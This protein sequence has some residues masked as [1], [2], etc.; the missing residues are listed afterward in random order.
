MSDR[1]EQVLKPF[2]D[3]K[4]YMDDRVKSGIE[5]YRKGFAALH[6]VD[7]SGK[8]VN[9]VHAE[10][11]QRTHDFRYGANLFM[12][13]ELETPEKNELYKQRFAEI[14]NLATL[15]F[16]WN[17]L[18]PEKGKQRYAADSPRIYR[19]PAPDLCIEYCKQHGI[20]PKMHCLCYDQTAP[21]WLPN[22][23]A[24]IRREYVRRMSEL[25]E[26]YEADIPS[27]EV[28][29]ETLFY[30][31]PTATAIYFD[32]DYVEWCFKAADRHFPNN[33]LLINEAHPNAWMA[34]NGTRS[35]YY[36]QIENLLLK[37]ARIDGIGMQ[38]HMF[39]RAE[40]EAKK[41]YLLYSPR[42]M[43]NVMD[44]YARF[45]KPLQVTELTVPSYTTDA[46]D[47]DIQAEIIKN[48]YSM[49]F[50]HPAM[51]AIIYWNLVDGYAAFAP[52]GDMTVGENYYRGGL[53]RFDF[54]PKPAFYAVRDLFGKIWRTQTSVDTGR[55][56]NSASF[57]GF[58]GEYDA[59][60]TVNDRTF[61]IGIHHTKQARRDITVRL[62]VCFD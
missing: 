14:F 19:R 13:D 17:D 6:F 2:F 22:D 27:W 45:G 34:F 15:P 44:C 11:K 4:E 25:S 16:Y 30:P 37:G 56:R 50:S 57:K 38:F 18:E 21:K 29:N 7:A 62:P 36:L 53:L 61:T 39:Y 23:V 60:V 58:Y 42:N 40:D 55:D 32:P 54:T 12:L 47:E 43:Y 48:I 26:R 5:E 41:T 51:E 28:T 3:E 59:T 1:R 46:E 8:P 33:R 20:E 9:N 52:Q 24:G 31:K 49:W 10:L 35:Q